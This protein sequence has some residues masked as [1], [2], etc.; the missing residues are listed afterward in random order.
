MAKIMVTYSTMCHEGREVV[1]KMAYDT[2]D[3]YADKVVMWEVSHNE[4]F[5]GVGARSVRKGLES[6]CSAKCTA[7]GLGLGGVRKS[8]AH[9]TNEIL[10]TRANVPI[11]PGGGF[12]EGETPPDGV[13][14][15]QLLGYFTFCC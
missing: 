13:T 4:T 2:R 6:L 7:S 15:N 3:G 9:L 1:K 5:V 14:T 10:E 11:P 8:G 12:V